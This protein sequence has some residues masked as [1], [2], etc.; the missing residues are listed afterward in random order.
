[1][2]RRVIHG[3][4]KRE[5][6]EIVKA[7]PMMGARD[8]VK[9]F[10]CDLARVNHARS[11]LGLTQKRP[12]ASRS[13]H[14]H[15]SPRVISVLRSQVNELTEANISLA[16][17]AAQDDKDEVIAGLRA[18]ITYLEMKLERANGTPV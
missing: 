17:S 2:K 11:E 12:F 6:V 7:N 14:T 1:M 15:D 9:Q 4:S 16:K 3:P 13:K 10:N 5:V 18:I 8:I